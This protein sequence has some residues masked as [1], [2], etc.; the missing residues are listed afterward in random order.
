MSM[1]AC[2]RGL[3]LAVLIGAL[4]CSACG[5][6]QTPVYPVSGAVLVDGQPAPRATITLHPVVDSGPEK[7]RPTAQVDEQGKFELTTFRKGDGAP[8]GEYR[9]TV[10]WYV[11][12]RV[13]PNDDPIPINQLPPRY[14][15]AE[16]S[17]LKA[18]VSKG[19]NVLQPFNL[20]VR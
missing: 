2:R 11:A 17:Q 9:V 12:T 16:T 18:I 20:E 4:S 3:A 8:E 6:K 14:A 13:S 15:R 10:V 1:M 5:K 19:N 7:H